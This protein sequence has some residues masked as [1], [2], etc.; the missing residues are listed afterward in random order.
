MCLRTLRL[1]RTKNILS[2]S[3]MGPAC[4]INAE[5]LK[6]DSNNEIAEAIM[7]DLNILVS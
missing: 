1:C 7:F 2:I 4:K 6:K 3:Q 5:A